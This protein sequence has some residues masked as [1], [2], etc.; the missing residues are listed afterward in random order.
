MDGITLNWQRV[1]VGL[2]LQYFSSPG[3][4]LRSTGSSLGLQDTTELQS[5]HPSGIPKQ[6]P[7]FP[8]KESGKQAPEVDP[9]LEGPA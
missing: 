8:S 6:F 9:V 4:E 2:I 5:R 1:W 3:R 7:F